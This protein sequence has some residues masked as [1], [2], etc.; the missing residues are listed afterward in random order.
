LP[1][2]QLPPVPKGQIR[3]ASWN[4]RIYSTG[5]RDDSELELIAD[6]LQQFDLIAIQE[7]RDEEVVQ[8]TLAILA[9]RG[10][11][12]QAIVSEPVGRSVTERYAFYYRP[13]RITPLDNGQIWPDTN[14]EFI[15]EPFY[16]SFKAGQFDFTLI[17][18]H[19][20]FG[21]SIGDRR[22]ENVL[23]DNVYRTVQDADPNEQDVILLGDFNLPPE[24]Q[25]MDEVDVLLDPVFSGVKTTISDASLYD[26]F[27]WGSV[28]E[29]TGESG[30]DR[31]DE[32]VFGDDDDAASLAVSDHRPIW[33]TFHTGRDDDG[34]IPTSVESS[35]WGDV[36]LGDR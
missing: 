10:E 24:D 11:A 21:D 4:I 35:N 28:L 15:R 19:V 23:L 9:A 20:L 14:D 6:R 29:W 16:A 2:A 8:R 3:I 32:A 18:I 5:S 13:D 26:N 12:Y 30:I 33:V 36:K 31:F 1:A 25:G 27:W 7:L 22:S 17:T 34:D